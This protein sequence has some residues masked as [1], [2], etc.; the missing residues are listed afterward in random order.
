MRPSQSLTLPATQAE[1]RLSHLRALVDALPVP[2]DATQDRI[3]AFAVIEALNTWTTFAR[4]FYL[5]CVFRATRSS[6]AKVSLGASAHIKSKADA[7]DFAVRTVKPGYA[8]SRKPPWDW[9]DEPT[10]YDPRVVL[11]L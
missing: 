9:R 10:W 5:S 4:S 1:K 2:P 7:I 8:K 6:G 11:K 3:V